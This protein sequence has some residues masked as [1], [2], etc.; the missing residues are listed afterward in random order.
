[1][2][3]LSINQESPELMTKQA[4]N[5]AFYQRGGAQKMVSGVQGKV[6]RCCPKVQ[7]GA[8]GSMFRFRFIKGKS[9]TD[10]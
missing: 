4:E 1:M 9:V 6:R 8:D 3:F 2:K 7:A 10:S 5:E